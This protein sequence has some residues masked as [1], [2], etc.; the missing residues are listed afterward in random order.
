MDAL[1]VLLGGAALAA[2]L[3]ARADPMSQWRPLIAEAAQ[4]CG[5][6]ELWI[7]RVMRAESGGYTLLDGQPI[8]S[9]R[10]AMGLMQLMPATWGDMR[11]RLGLGGDPD[12]PHDNILAGACY[13]RMMYDRF[14]YPG[15]FGAYNAGPIRYAAWLAGRAALPG[16]TITY[17]GKV[18]TGPVFKPS[19]RP[20]PSLFVAGREPSSAAQSTLFAILK[21]VP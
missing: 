16:E 11:L 1:R 7:A 5:V 19:P 3:P 6:P 4:R 15:L 21:T 10:G 2:A 14:G 12:D 20:L 8:R 18:Q 9:P 17:L 13:L